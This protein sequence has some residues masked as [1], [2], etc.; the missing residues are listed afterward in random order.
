MTNFWINYISDLFEETNVTINAT[1]DFLFIT[2]TEIEY[3]WNVLEYVS[4][5]GF[6]I[7]RLENIFVIKV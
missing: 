5:Y 1:S 6:S 3:L 7:D 2:D 4:W